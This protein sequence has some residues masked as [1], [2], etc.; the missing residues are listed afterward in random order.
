MAGVD[1]SSAPNVSVCCLLL[2]WACMGMQVHV[3]FQQSYAV[4]AS[5]SVCP[6]ESGWYARQQCTG[7][8][9]VFSGSEV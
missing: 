4:T 9:C 5:V 8:A 3:M 6:P 7:S 1:L 2:A